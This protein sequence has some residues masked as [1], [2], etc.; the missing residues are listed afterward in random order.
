[1]V[2]GYRLSAACS[3][4]ITFTSRQWVTLRMKLPAV[5]DALNTLPGAS[6]T[7]SDSAARATSA[8]SRP[9]F[10]AIFFLACVAA[11]E[12]EQVVWEEI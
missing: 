6:T 10:T 1:M 4:D 8:E 3:V 9:S 11:L 12:L 5:C 7:L 2:C